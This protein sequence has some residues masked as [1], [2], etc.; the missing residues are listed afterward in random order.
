MLSVQKQKELEVTKQQQLYPSIMKTII[1]VKQKNGIIFL[2]NENNKKNATFLVMDEIYT[3]EYFSTLTKKKPSFS[4]KFL[5][6]LIFCAWQMAFT[7]IAFKTPQSMPNH[8][9]IIATS[10]AMHQKDISFR[11]S[12]SWFTSDQFSFTCDQNTSGKIG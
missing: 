10:A 9:V 1:I 4:A 7:V 3:P 2:N 6:C 5:Y 8:R 12:A 11:F